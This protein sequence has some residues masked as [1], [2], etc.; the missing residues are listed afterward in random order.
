ML[1]MM[2]YIKK[3]YPHTA[4]EREREREKKS[5]VRDKKEIKNRFFVVQQNMASLSLFHSAFKLFFVFLI[6]LV[7]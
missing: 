5:A 2:L 4:K 1:L 6:C 3:R 7:K